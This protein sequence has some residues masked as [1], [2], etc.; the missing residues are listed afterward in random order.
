M[1]CHQYPTG[2]GEKGNFLVI[3]LSGQCR[4]QHKL[5]GIVGDD[6]Q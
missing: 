6:N 4:P 5:K 3:K 2:N 1:F